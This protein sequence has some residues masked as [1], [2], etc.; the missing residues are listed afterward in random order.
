PATL[1][2][3]EAPHR[4]IKCLG[5]CLEILGDR[6]AAVGRELTKLH[7]TTHRGRLSELKGHFESVGVKG[8]IVL[9][10]AAGDPNPKVP[11]GTKTLLERVAE[12]EL[13][14]HDHK[15]ALKRAAKEFGMSKSAAYKL[16]LDSVSS[17][18]NR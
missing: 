8:E 4:L 18:S 1:V 10:V 14:G 17:A 2:F 7:E 5:D 9:S 6:P 3:Y 15:A 16:V 11:P 12:L 13:E